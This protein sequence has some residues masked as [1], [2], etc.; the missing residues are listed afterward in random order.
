MHLLLTHRIRRDLQ[1]VDTLQTSSS[2]LP[3]DPTKF[4]VPGGKT[5]LEEAVKTLGGIVKL[6]D[7]VLQSLGQIRDLGIVQDK[8]EVRVGVG[9]A[10]AYFHAIR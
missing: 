6:Y 9:G 10:E 3:A 8:D 7:T 1:L 2:A 5:K 4:K